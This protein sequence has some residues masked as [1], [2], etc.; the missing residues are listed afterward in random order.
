MATRSR[1]QK[2]GA[3]GQA[4]L[5][6]R[7]EEHDDWLART[8]GEDYGV[9]IEAEL[10][11]EGVIQGEILKIQIKT[12][13][14]PTVKEGAIKFEIERKYIEYAQTCRY[15]VVLVLVDITEGDAWYL[16]VQ[17]WLIR[18]RSVEGR[19][20]SIQDSWTQWVTLENSISSGLNSE[21]KRI[22]QWRGETQLILSL[23]DSLRAAAATYNKDI[24]AALIGIIS[25]HANSVADVSL[26]ALID[27]AL[28]LN[29][30]LR[31]THK[32]NIIAEQLFKLV[33]QF[34]DRVSKATILDLVLRG[35]SYS[36]TGLTALG[37]LYDDFPD[38]LRNLNLP[39]QFA[40]IEPRVAYYCA[41]REKFPDHKSADMFVDP[42]GFVFAGFRYVQPDMHWDKY[43][44]RGPSALLDYLIPDDGN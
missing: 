28:R 3:K 10:V 43:A 38:H 6:A 23:I 30:R 19:L 12:T 37:I 36:R 17:E 29:D 5:I 25:Q 35:D 34:G 13:S 31:G 22:A 15:P 20:E 41:F 9:D 18:R 42:T 16:W 1:A 14:K 24:I 8:L 40:N 39:D 44:N 21:L 11:E 7:I 32:G 26:D 2:I 27:E 4:W 33:R